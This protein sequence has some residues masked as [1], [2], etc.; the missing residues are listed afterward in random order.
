MGMSVPAIT[1]YSNQNDFEKYLW[2]VSIIE[3]SGG[4][5]GNQIETQQ[6]SEQPPQPLLNC[7]NRCEWVISRE[8]EAKQVNWVPLWEKI[9]VSDQVYLW[10]QKLKWLRYLNWRYSLCPPK[11]HAVVWIFGKSSLIF[12]M[13]IPCVDSLPLCFCPVA[14]NWRRQVL[15]I[16]PSPRKQIFIALRSIVPFFSC[17]TY[18]R[19]P[20]YPCPKIS[21]WMCGLNLVNLGPAGNNIFILERLF[22]SFYIPE[23]IFTSAL[24]LVRISI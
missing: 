4:I 2:R 15:P 1:L 22:N 14:K 18:L 7:R 16:L 23:L 9:L 13:L 3:R 19:H 6:M 5:W 11:S 12:S 8:V 17:S 10:I 24:T 21:S 20:L